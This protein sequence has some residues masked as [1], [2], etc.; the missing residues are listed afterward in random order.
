MEIMIWKGCGK[1]QSSP[2]SNLLGDGGKPRISS[3]RIVFAV[4]ENST[5]HLQNAHLSFYATSAYCYV[6]FLKKKKSIAPRIS[7]G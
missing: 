3:G 4:V 1:M 7:L 2:N 5:K 6:I